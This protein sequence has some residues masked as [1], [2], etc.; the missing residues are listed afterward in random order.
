[1]AGL[2]LAFI[3]VARREVGRG[4]ASIS[5]MMHNDAALDMTTAWRR[6]LVDKARREI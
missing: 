4:R 6:I 1:M 2:A 3:T 5:P